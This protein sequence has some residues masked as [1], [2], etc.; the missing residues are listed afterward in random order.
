MNLVLD[1]AVEVQLATKDTEEQRRELGI[2][3]TA[4]VEKVAKDYRANTTQRRQCST[5][6]TTVILSWQ[7][8]AN[9]QCRIPFA[10]SWSNTIGYIYPAACLLNT[11]PSPL[12]RASTG[13][14]DSLVG[15][16]CPSGRS[17]CCKANATELYQH[18]EISATWG[19]H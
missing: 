7:T 14:S 5:D 18:G 19:T 3:N 12:M 10:R 6:T 9:F 13:Q 4:I 11:D 8:A 2:P 1:D 16:P 17:C 15:M